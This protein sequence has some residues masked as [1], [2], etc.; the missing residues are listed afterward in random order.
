MRIKKSENPF[1]KMATERGL[2]VVEEGQLFEYKDRF[3]EVVFRPL[4]TKNMS[5]ELKHPT[6]NFKTNLMGVFTRPSSDKG[7][8]YCG[9]ISDIYHFIGHDVLCNRIRTS[10]SSI[11]KPILKENIYLTVDN[12]TMNAE[13]VI[14]NQVSVPK[15]GDVYP[16][17][18]LSNNYNGKKAATISFGFRCNDYSF[19]FNL[20]LLRQIHTE[21]ASTRIAADIQSY[22]NTF[23]ENIIDVVD[24]SFNA[25]LTEVQMLSVLD[26][27]EEEVGK[28]RREKV[29]VI[30]QD[31]QKEIT[32]SDSEKKLPAAWHLFLALTRYSSIESNLNARKLIENVAESVLVVPNKMADVL[33][34]LK[35]GKTV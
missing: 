16:T 18:V 30:F 19:V 33:K 3:A 10:I 28:R 29:S 31:I 26:L 15:A 27:I 12:T 13:M 35:S 8:M 20:G 25:E 9:I 24:Q 34:K 4:F 23:T 2:T 1:F 32:E 7:Y 14:Q 11:G 6:D 17:V 5:E 21:Y 22:L